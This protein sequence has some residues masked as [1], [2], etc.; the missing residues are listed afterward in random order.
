MRSRITPKQ[1]TNV[2]RKNFAPL[3]VALTAGCAT[4]N[5]GRVQPL[6]NAERSLYTCREI[7][8]EIAKASDFLRNIEEQKKGISDKDV[9]AFLGDFGIGNSMEY[10][11]A[12]KSGV[13]RLTQLQELHAANQCPS[14]AVAVVPA[15]T[16]QPQPGVSA[17]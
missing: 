4:V 6:S 9:L 10:A 16:P 17:E 3:I 11:D 12:T 1:E 13:E 8:L 14:T 7:E 15:V 5:Y 2:K